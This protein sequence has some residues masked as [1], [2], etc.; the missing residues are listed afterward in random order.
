M[1]VAL[2]RRLSRHFDRRANV[3]HSSPLLSRLLPLVGL[4]SVALFPAQTAQAIPSIEPGTVDTAAISVAAEPGSS[5]P[6]E[7]QSGGTNTGNGNKLTTIPIVGWTARGGLPVSLSLFHNSQGGGNSELGAKWTNSYDIYLV[8]DPS[9]GTASV[10]WGDALGYPFALDVSTGGLFR[11]HGN[12]RQPCCDLGH[13]R[14]SNLL[15]A[16][17]EERHHLSVQRRNGKPLELRVHHGPQQQH[18]HDFPQQRRLRDR[19]HR[20]LGPRLDVHL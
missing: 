2:S 16:D 15:C 17:H 5:Y 20:S 7:G 4:L 1:A 9:T 6:W 19:R 12:P 8:T 10:Q 11:S 3:R 18:H 13:E 14:Q